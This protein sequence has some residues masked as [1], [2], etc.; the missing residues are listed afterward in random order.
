MEN[1]KTVINVED[2]GFKVNI[3]RLLRDV[4]KMTD[5]LILRK[6]ITKHDKEFIELILD[7]SEQ[8]LTNLPTEMEGY[9][10]VAVLERESCALKIEYKAYNGVKE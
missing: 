7:K 9:W 4:K 2:V 1:E 10:S 3:Q 8:V 6:T 5:K